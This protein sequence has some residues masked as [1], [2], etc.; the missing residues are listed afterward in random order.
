MLNVITRKTEPFINLT[1]KADC[2]R[3]AGRTVS[4]NSDSVFRHPTYM[5]LLT[6]EK[7]E[8]AIAFPPYGLYN[9]GQVQIK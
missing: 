8:D 6:G 3:R 1:R 5:L 2:T 4:W 7:V 9:W